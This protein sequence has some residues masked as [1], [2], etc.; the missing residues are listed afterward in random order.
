MIYKTTDV[1]LIKVQEK[2]KLS[3][4]VKFFDKPGKIQGKQVSAGVRLRQS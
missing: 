4:L 3:Q 2:L 1:K